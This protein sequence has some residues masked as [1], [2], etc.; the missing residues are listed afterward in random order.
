VFKDERYDGSENVHGRIV[1]C[2]GIRVAGFEGSHWYNGG[3]HQYSDSQMARLVN[4]VRL[5]TVRSGPPDV[6]LTHAPPLGCH[7][8]D[9]ACHRGFAAFNTAIEAWKP[10][11]FLHGHMHAY[12]RRQG[13]ATIGETRIINPFPYKLIHLPVTVPQLRPASDLPSIQGLT[14]TTRVT[15]SSG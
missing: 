11:L 12:D 14:A 1:E 7:D 13:E 6:V 5:K 15:R 10:R 8:G 3:K 9:D 2:K 4:R